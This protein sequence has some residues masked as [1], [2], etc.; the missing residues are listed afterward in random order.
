MD[1]WPG[2]VWRLPCSCAPHVVKE[3]ES[4]WWVVRSLAWAAGQTALSTARCW[5]RR[6]RDL[7]Q[8]FVH[9]ILSI[10]WEHSVFPQNSWALHQDG[11]TEVQQVAARAPISCPGFSRMAAQLSNLTAAVAV[12]AEQLGCGAAWG[13]L[14]GH[15]PHPWPTATLEPP[16]F[17]LSATAFLWD[18]SCLWG[19]EALVELLF[20]SLGSHL[21]G[22]RHLAE[23]VLWPFWLPFSSLLPWAWS[24]WLSW[25]CNY[26]PWVVPELSCFVYQEG[27]QFFQEYC[28]TF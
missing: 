22:W 15:C 2:S 1:L 6:R 27:S 19:R 21:G 11:C 20:L 17:G 24:S 25:G 13:P 10:S 12:W 23:P 4:L 26:L 7:P 16:R 18:C 5:V 28:G 3:L 8:C 9:D 14:V